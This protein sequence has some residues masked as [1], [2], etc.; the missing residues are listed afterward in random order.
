LSPLPPRRARRGS[1]ERPVNS[2]LYRAAW[3]AVALP[4]LIAAFTVTRPTALPRPTLPPTFSG[5]AAA[6][7][8]RTFDRNFPNRTPGSQTAAAAVTEPGGILDLFAPFG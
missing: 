3:L 6:A 2:R 8:A 5:R 4:L 7:I 1:V